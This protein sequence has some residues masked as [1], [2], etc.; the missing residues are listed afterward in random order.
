MTRSNALKAS[1]SIPLVSSSF[2]YVKIRGH[3]SIPPVR[4]SHVPTMETYFP[5]FSASQDIYLFAFLSHRRAVWQSIRANQRE[6]C[7]VVTLK[8]RNVRYSNV[9]KEGTFTVEFILSNIKNSP[10][11]FSAM[12]ARSPPPHAPRAMGLSEN[13]ADFD[14]PPSTPWWW[15]LLFYDVQ[16]LG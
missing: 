1:I 12:P 6:Y 14:A 9:W 3:A 11:E 8:A 7:A 5:L 15:Y 13:A 2:S 4:F 16:Y 10:D